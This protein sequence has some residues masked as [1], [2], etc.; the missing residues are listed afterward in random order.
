MRVTLADS[1]FI[2]C[3]TA[4]P[5]YLK[6]C[7]NLQSCSSGVSKTVHVG[8]LVLYCVLPNLAND[9]VLGM[10]WLHAINPQIDWSAY[11]LYIDLRGHTVCILITK[12]GCFYTNAEVCSLKSVLKTMHCDK[13]SA[14]LGVLRP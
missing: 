4:F 14:W 10:D 5:L 11:S 9:V 3:S 8:C 13:V 7:G 2:D 6:Q 1:S 12:K